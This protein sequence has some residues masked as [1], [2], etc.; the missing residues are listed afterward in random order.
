MRA[1]GSN[2]NKQE[3]PGMIT[4]G[5]V[6]GTFGIRGEL[7]VFLYNPQTELFQSSRAVTLL[8]ENGTQK[9]AKLKTRSGAGKKILG[10][11]PGLHNPQQASQYVGAKICV[12]IEDLPELEDEEWYHFQLLGLPVHTQSQRYL[13]SIVEIITAQVD[14]WVVEGEDDELLY[15]PN[16]EG[17]IVSVCISKADAT[18]DK[19]F[20]VVIYDFDD[21]IDS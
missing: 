6:S 7:K 17:H 14:I 3:I 13:G 10:S 19:P 11:M 12:P 16:E 1:D 8:F 21:E 18:E 15:V 2:I 4:L 9:E 20:G 5:Y